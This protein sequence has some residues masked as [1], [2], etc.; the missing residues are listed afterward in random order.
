[1][2]LSRIVRQFRKSAHLGRFAD[3]NRQRPA[4]VLVAGFSD[5]IDGKSP[6]TLDIRDSNSG[7]GSDRGGNDILEGAYRARESAVQFLRTNSGAKKFVDSDG[8]TLSVSPEVIS[9]MIRG[10]LEKND[11]E[12]IMMVILEADRVKKLN[13]AILDESIDECLRASNHS[14]ATALLT[15]AGD[16][17]FVVS[18]RVCQNLLQTLVNHCKWRPAATTASYMIRRDYSFR[19]REVFF[20]VGGLMKDSAGAAEAL[21]MMSVIADKRR[22]DVSGLFSFTKVR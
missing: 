14:S 4:C 9:A 15:I 17:N 13:G 5:S 1:M 16:R 19:D 6:R 18:E 22:S 2:A 7:N 8:E 3:D 20:I 10:A 11:N 12:T 21:N